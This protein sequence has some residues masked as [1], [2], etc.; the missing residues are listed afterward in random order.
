MNRRH[1]DYQAV[2]RVERDVD[3]EKQI[4]RLRDELTKKELE[5]QGIRAM[6]VLKT[7]RKCLKKP[8]RIHFQGV[9]DEKI[10]DRDAAIRQLKVT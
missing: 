1:P 4:Q 9:D 10:H 2:R 8:I 6:K 3:A 7:Q 5:L